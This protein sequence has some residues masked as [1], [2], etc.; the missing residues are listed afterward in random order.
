MK[1]PGS[2]IFMWLPNM[3]VN[4]YEGK[5]DGLL[6]PDSVKWGNFRGTYSGT[7]KRGIS[8]LDE[9]DMRRKPLSIEIN[10]EI[11]DITDFYVDIAQDLCRMGF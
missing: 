7:S 11:R 4:K 5:N 2:D 8:H 3:V 1:K 6:T 9:I 10:N